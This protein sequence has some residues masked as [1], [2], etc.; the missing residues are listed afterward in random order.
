[1]LVIPAVISLV[2]LLLYASWYQSSISRM[3]TVAN[4]KPMIATDIPE[5]VWETVAGREVFSES[6]VYDEIEK[7]NQI[8]D[9]L[10]VG[11]HITKAEYEDCLCKLSELNG[12]VVRLPQDEIDKRLKRKGDG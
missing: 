7:V 11:K 5:A 9:E 6:A 8:L 2:M 4:L 10:I 1:M 12:G 3:E